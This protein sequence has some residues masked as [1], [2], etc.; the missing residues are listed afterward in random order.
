MIMKKSF[1]LLRV[2]GL[3][4]GLVASAATMPSV[5]AATSATITATGTVPVACSVNGANITMAKNDAQTLQG[6]ATNVAYTTG[7]ATIF[8]LSTPTLNAPSGYGGY[9][10]IALV[11]DNNAVV[12]ASSNGGGQ[13]YTVPGAESGVFTYEA[14]VIGTTEE[15]KPGVYT[16]SSTLTCVGQ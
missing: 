4:A 5:H 11:K 1:P 10:F 14:G 16:V 13:S 8:S 2:I 7:S 12:Y 3:S 15:L 9:G 6:V